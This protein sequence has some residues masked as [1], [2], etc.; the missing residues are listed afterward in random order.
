M[1]SA[2]GSFEDKVVLVTGA[3]RGIGKAVAVAFAREG[4]RVAINYRSNKDAA[5]ETA[6]LVE[7]AGGKAMVVQADVSVRGDCEKLVDQVVEKWGTIHVLVN[8]A[9][10]TRDGLI[11]GLDENDWDTVLKTN[12]EGTVF[13]FKS[14]CSAHDDAKVRS[15]S[16]YIFSVCGQ[17][18]S[19]ARFVFI[20]KRCC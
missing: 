19:W 1:G 20:F 8:N 7:Q 15:N 12:L 5:Q 14:S 6:S 13:S 3:S 11:M 2:K 16:E 9:G 10:V 4:A 17:W 18:A